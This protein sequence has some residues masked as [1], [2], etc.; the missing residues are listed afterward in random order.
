M[1]FKMSFPIKFPSSIHKI[2]IVKLS[3]PLLF[4]ILFSGCGA[5]NNKITLYKNNVIVAFGDSLTEGKG[6]SSEQSYPSVLQREL[7]IEVINAG[8]SGETSAKGLNRFESV[9]KAHLPGLVI[10]CHGGNDILRKMPKEKLEQNIEAMLNLANKYGAQ[11]MLVGVPQ[12]S[13]SLSSL[14]LYERL[15]E[16]HNLVAELE[17]LPDLLGTPAMK[18]DRVHLN[19]EGYK[20]FA[21][22]LADRIVINY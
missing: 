3:L 7:G 15:A 5:Q 10:L 13:L 21:L 17:I 8:I 22:A 16:K 20:A 2:R 1:H 18:S 11:V 9:L 19:E 12:P 4:I 6:T 14:S